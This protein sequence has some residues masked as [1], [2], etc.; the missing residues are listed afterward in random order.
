PIKCEVK[1]PVLIEIID[2]EEQDKKFEVAERHQVEDTEDE[3]SDKDEIDEV[4]D[5]KDEIDEVQ[6]TEDEE[7]ELEEKGKTKDEQQEEPEG[8][9]QV[10]VESRKTK[11]KKKQFVIENSDNSKELDAWT[12]QDQDQ[13][14]YNSEQV[15]NKQIE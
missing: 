3:Q 14:G 8:S 2:E 6:D 11:N 9:E 5:T 13:E 10:V 12:S 4:H 15:N 1:T 7:M